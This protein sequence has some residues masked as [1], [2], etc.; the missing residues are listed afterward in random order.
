M[1]VGPAEA[2]AGAAEKP[3]P[4][5]SDAPQKAGVGRGR[6]CELLRSPVPWEG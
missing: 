5:A 1:A 4:M 6:C 2:D 3:E